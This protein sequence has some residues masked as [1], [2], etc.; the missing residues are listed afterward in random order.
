MKYVKANGYR[1]TFRVTALR[2]TEDRSIRPARFATS[3]GKLGI[4]PASALRPRPTANR[5][6]TRLLLPSLIL[7]LLLPR[8]LLF[9]QLHRQ[10][11]L[12]RRSL[13]IP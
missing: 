10:R 13:G 3:A 7:P 6:L 8:L 4:S 12:L 9:S 2:R 5:L 1:V 11:L